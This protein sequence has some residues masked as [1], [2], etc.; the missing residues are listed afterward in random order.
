MTPPPLPEPPKPSLEELITDWV[1]KILMAGGI[2]AGSAGA[3]WQL[4][5]ESDIPKAIVSALIGAGVSYGA[6]ILQPIHKGNQKRLEQFGADVNKEVDEIADDWMTRWKFSDFEGKYLICQ[7]LDCEEDDP[8]GVREDEDLPIHNPLLQEIFVPLELSGESTNFLGYSETEIRSL[9]KQINEES[10]QIWQLLKCTKTD[11]RLRQIAIRAIGGYGKTTLLK[12]LAYIYSIRK[13]SKYKAPKFIPFLIYL[14]NCWKEITQDTPP[15]LPDLLSSFHISRLPK[16]KKLEV[17]SKWAMNLLNKGEALILLDGFDEIPPGNR[18]KASQWLTRQ[19]KEYPN[20]VFILTSRPTAYQEDYTARKLT[21]NFWIKD[22]NKDQRKEFVEQWYRCQERRARGNRSTPYVEQKVQER[23]ASL[24][25]QIEARP[26]LK[27]LAGNPLLLNMMA[28]FHRSRQ[29]ADAS[30]QLPD[31][32]VELYQDICELQLGRRPKAKGLDYLLLNSIHQRQEVLQRV[33]LEMMKRATPED[34]E[35]F[36]QIEESDLLELLKTALE[37]F[38]PHLEPKEFLKQLV[39]VSEFLVHRDGRTSRI[40]QFSHLSF[41][42]FLAAAE[43]ARSQQLDLIY[44]NLHLS[45]WKDLILFYAG[46]INPVAVIALIPQIIDRN[47]NDLAY[48]IYRQTDRSAPL[49]PAQ[50]KALNALKDRVI[51]AWTHPL[52]TYLNN[53][54]WRE[55]DE[56]TYRLMITAVGKE[57]GQYFS[58]DDLRNFPCDELLAIDRLWVQYS[59]GLYGFS[60]QKEIYVECG[61]KLDFSYPGSKTWDDFVI[62]IRWQKE[63]GGEYLFSEIYEEEHMNYKGHLPFRCSQSGRLLWGGWVT[64]FLASRLVKCNL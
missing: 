29:G 36:K 45:T 62:K 18:E 8:T 2:G 20:S 50:R 60:V 34:E 35:G 48:A 14:A 52:E 39:Q 40:Y 21:A 64:S 7:Q 30:V 33:A 13:Y 17:P 42:E 5:K 19:M 31:R 1:Y 24:L 32:K 44:Q 11:N 54:Q 38:D 12:H 49:S 23:S 6:A 16:G 51:S 3:F 63:K 61:G 28:R 37:P 9:Q 22:F 15:I 57:T 53:K 10:M 4:F 26:E 55:A 59:N 25:A 41:Q 56:E 58:E 43:I 47:G 46:L 27:R